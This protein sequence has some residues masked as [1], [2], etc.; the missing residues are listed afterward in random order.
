MWRNSRS[1]YFRG[2]IEFIQSL[3]TICFL[4][5]MAKGTGINNKALHKNLKPTFAPLNKEFI[6]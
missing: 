3:V 5:T 6:I 2:T 4:L 1:T